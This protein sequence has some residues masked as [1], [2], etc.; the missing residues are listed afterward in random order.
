LALGRQGF[1]GLVVQ[2]RISKRGQYERVSYVIFQ[3]VETERLLV[4][5][6]NE[7]LETGISHLGF[8]IN[9]GYIIELV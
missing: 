8:D 3:D 4:V 9:M 1:Q 6:K 7:D 2:Y 5:A